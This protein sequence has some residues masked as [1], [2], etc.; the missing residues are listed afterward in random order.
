MIEDLDVKVGP[1]FYRYSKDAINIIPEILK[2][3]QAKNIM[4][5]HGTISWEKAKPFLKKVV[6]L[7]N[8]IIYVQYHGECSYNECHRIADAIRENEIDFVIGVGGG[9][10]SDLVLYT[11]H[12]TNTPFGLVPTLASNCA[13]WTPLSVMYKDNGL[14]EGKTEHVKRQAAFLITDPALVID[15]PV[16][17]FIAG[18][19]DTMAKWY[20]SDLILEQKKFSR[21]PFPQ[22][23][24]FTARMCKDTILSESM[25]SI[26]DMKNKTI[27]DEFI[28]VSE[29]IIAVSGL[30]GG[31][32]DKYARNT[33]AHAIHDAI[34]AYIPE[35]HKYLHGE[36]VAYGIFYQLALE[37][38][39]S[40]IDELIPFY[41]KLNLPKSLSEMGIYPFP[42]D[43]LRDIIRFVNSKQKVHLLPIEINET[44]L[45]ETLINLENYIN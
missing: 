43:L 30:V 24:R 20:E 33:A 25:K 35:A 13:A 31:F 10:L 38:K 26:E 23:A 36:K 11:C 29:I 28:H 45:T 19:A 4:I 41:E 40:V 27:S 18:I 42:D 21:E 17:Y 1:Q 15:S 6:S 32:G 44:V 9:K 2:E 5:I 14:A 3:Y 12:L 34:S 39:W 22:L 16:K 7:D 37:G 8:K